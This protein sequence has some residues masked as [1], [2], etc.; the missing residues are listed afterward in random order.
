MT[1]V[2]SSP[3]GERLGIYL[4]LL[5]GLLVLSACTKDELAER[6]R[7]CSDYV[8]FGVLPKSDGDRC[9]YEEGIFKAAAE[10]ITDR[11]VENIYPILIEA[12]RRMAASSSRLDKTSFAVLSSDIPAPGPFIDPQS[13]TT[14]HAAIDLAHVTFDAPTQD[15]DFQRDWWEIS[16]GRSGRPD[17]LWNLKIVGIGPYDFDGLETVCQLLAY[18][19]SAEGCKARVYI[20]LDKKSIAP[21]LG[22]LG[23]M[24]IDFIPPTRDEVRRVLLD[25]ELEHWPPNH[26]S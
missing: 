23:V 13:S 12:S 22:E 8:K 15:P 7:A 18:S 2:A 19:Q 24:A 9:V 10:T 20:D 25:S 1:V 3:L 11:Q 4:V 16:G 5:A 21:D 6:K 17:D 14:W 26:T